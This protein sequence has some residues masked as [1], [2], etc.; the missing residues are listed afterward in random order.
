MYVS[1]RFYSNRYALK[2]FDKYKML[3]RF[4]YIFLGTDF[5]RGHNI[6]SSSTSCASSFEWNDHKLHHWLGRTFLL[7][8]I[9]FGDDTR[10]F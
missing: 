2:S 10:D 4:N 1:I 6:G 3:E 8:E 7:V 5:I 9:Y